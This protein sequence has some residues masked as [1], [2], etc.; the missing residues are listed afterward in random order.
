PPTGS[1]SWTPAAS[2]RWSRP[3]S[4]S[5]PRRPLAPGTSWA[6]SSTTDPPSPSTPSVPSNENTMSSS[7][8]RRLFLTG[9]VGTVAAVTLAACG[10]GAEDE[11]AVAEVEA[12][13]FPEGS[14][15]ARLSEAGS[16]KI[17]TKFDQPLFGQA[18]PDGD[19]V[20]FD[21]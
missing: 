10:G 5:P 1:C 21:V 4:S 18:G 12:A 7:L 3:S 15:M 14:T 20:G 19:P 17:G 13:D 8:N 16:I 6:R 11:P 2:S 9:T